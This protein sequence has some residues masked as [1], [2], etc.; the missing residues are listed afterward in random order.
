[1][2]AELAF[3]ITAASRPDHPRLGAELER[4]GYAELWTN[5]TRRGDGI[6]TLAAVAP[7]TTRLRL[8]V[9]V[10]ALSEHGP[11]AISDRVTGS[12]LPADRFVLGV[13]SGSSASLDRVRTGVAELRRLLPE[14]Q[15]AVAAVGPRMARLAGEIADLVVANWALPDRLS[16]VR[17]R[18]GEGAGAARRD[19]PRFVA[20]VRTAIGSGAE[21]RLR[22]EMDRYRDYGAG[23]Y[24]RAFD[25]QPDLP[26]GVALERPGAAA[27]AAALGPY[28][29]VVDTLVVRGLPVEDSVDAWL[30]IARLAAGG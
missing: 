12:P 26:V 20:Y 1:M 28:H 13:G 23:H 19:P 9:G 11:A 14:T 22:A 10:I 24:A 17:E 8:G 27:M 5:D 29:D 21:T 15:I 2:P 16:W 7:G 18:V 4:L 3:G 25:A 6:A 30:E